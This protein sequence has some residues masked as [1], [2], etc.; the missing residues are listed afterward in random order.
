MSAVQVKNLSVQF[1]DFFAV[2][3]LSFSVEKGEV[4]GF[5]GANGAGKTT[6]IRVLCGL[7]LP[8]AGQASVCG[9][10]VLSDAFEVKKK[11]G[12]MSQKFTLYDDLT[13]KENL[14]FTSALRKMEPEKFR[15]QKEKLLK[16]IRFKSSEDILVR[17]LP[18]GIKQQV[19]LVAAVLHDPEIVFLD[20]P[21][22]GVSPAFRQRFWKLIGGL[23]AEGK[24]V[25]VTTHYMDEAEQCGRIALMKSG[26]LIALDSPQELKRNSFPDR[27]PQ[28]VSLEDVFIEQV[29]GG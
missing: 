13:V 11:V 4:F 1:G 8:S 25:F 22:A 18:G 21:T 2:K 17:D 26:E 28:E 16:M 9:L 29:E 23:A 19:S 20:E 15:E 14:D 7:L 3:D 24:T 12:Y 5:L 6:T 27:E 10:D